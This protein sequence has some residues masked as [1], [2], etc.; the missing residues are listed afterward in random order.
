V[1]KVTN[2]FKSSAGSADIKLG[3]NGFHGGNLP[4]SSRR[5]I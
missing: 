4:A 5:T 1:Y 3:S 2:M